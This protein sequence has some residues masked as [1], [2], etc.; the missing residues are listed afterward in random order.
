M[1]GHADLGTTERY[2]RLRPAA[3]RRVLRAPAR[4]PQDRRTRILRLSLLAAALALAAG[5]CSGQ[6]DEMAA[7]PALDQKLITA[8]YSNDV[9][10]ARG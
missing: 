10:A 1:L 7:G 4:P 8:A 2:T 3:A 6:D 5:G 9:D